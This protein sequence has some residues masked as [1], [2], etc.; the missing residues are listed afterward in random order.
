MDAAVNAVRRV[1]TEMRTATSQELRRAN[2]TS[3]VEEPLAEVT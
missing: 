2:R 3:Q 1:L